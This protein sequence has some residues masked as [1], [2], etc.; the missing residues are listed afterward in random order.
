MA[1]FLFVWQNL[2]MDT[3]SITNKLHLRL[4]SKKT[5]NKY[6]LLSCQCLVVIE[7]AQSKAIQRSCIFWIAPLRS[8]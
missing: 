7:T 1:K 8:Q 3:D 5:F 6:I 4:V 2:Y